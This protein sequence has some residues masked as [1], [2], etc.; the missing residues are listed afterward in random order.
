MKK[1]LELMLAR[2][3]EKLKT[4]GFTINLTDEAKEHLLEKG[5]DPHYGARPLQRTIQR[6]VE[7]TLA[8]EIL[9][10]RFSAPSTIYVDFDADE[11]RLTFNTQPVVKAV[12]H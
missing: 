12:K 7:D 10:K 11:K 1:I 3:K 8:T 4:Q 6:L 9:A 5:F 2:V